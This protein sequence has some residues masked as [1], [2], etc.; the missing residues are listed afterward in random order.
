[1]IKNLGVKITAPFVIIFVVGLVLL[2]ISLLFE[3]ILP[4]I[5]ST[6]LNVL[7]ISFIA[8]SLSAPISE[9][10]Q[11]KTLS[12]HIRILQ[13]AQ[14]SGIIHVL[15]SRVE[16]KD[17][18][19][20]IVEDEFAK[21]DRI[22]MAGVA[23]PRIFHSQPYPAPI[24]EK[25][26]NPNIPIKVLLLNPKGENANE[27][28][29]IEIGRGTV[30]DINRSIGSLRL[31]AKERM[32]GL[33][34]NIGN[35]ENYEDVIDKIK[36]EVHLYDFSPIAFMIQTDNCLFLEQYHFGRLKSLRLGE[37][38]G[39]RTP[40]VVYSSNSTTYK[41]MEQHFIYIWENKSKDI[42]RDFL[43]KTNQS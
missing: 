6:I 18:F 1:M 11:F 22:L 37:C 7:G 5:W 39:G 26:F 17:S 13:G 19:F 24:D 8:V 40:L 10:F 31:I 42:S 23:F 30:E 38:I 33:E 12:K 43:V 3:T 9:F 41:I 2:I 20:E 14:S 27:R 29:K 15:A 28:A 34:I 36:I 16:D 32:K 4:N 21:A 25:M 35:E